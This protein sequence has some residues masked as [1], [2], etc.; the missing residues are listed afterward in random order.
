MYGLIFLNMSMCIFVII[1]TPIPDK[2]T[3]ADTTEAS[4]IEISSFFFL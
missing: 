4:A 2:N 3:I 1:T